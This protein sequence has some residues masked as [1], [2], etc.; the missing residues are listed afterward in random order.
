MKFNF[1]DNGTQFDSGSNRNSNG[2]S[3]GSK[4]E[5]SF[6]RKRKA[7]FSNGVG[8]MKQVTLDFA[9]NVKSFLKF[10]EQP[11]TALSELYQNFRPFSQRR[12]WSGNLARDYRFTLS[13]SVSFKP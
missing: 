2:F 9:E 7:E 13:S 5:A 10:L 11:R 8:V 1:V 6:N 12:I 3:Y 4:D